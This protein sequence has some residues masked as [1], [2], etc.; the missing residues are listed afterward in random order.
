M[1]KFIFPLALLYFISCTEKKKDNSNDTT[2]LNALAEQYVRLGLSIGQYDKDFVDAYYGPDSLKP[3]LAAAAVF[4]KDS[5]LKAVNVLSAELKIFDSNANDTI[6]KRSAWL[7]S[8]L[9]AFERRIKLFGGDSASFDDECRELYGVTAPVYDSARFKNIIRKLDSLLPGKGT[10]NERMQQL[11]GR[12]IIPKEKLDTVLKA[13]IAECRK[14]TLQHY[15]L[16]ANENFSL[17][18][19]NNK[20]WSGYNWYKGNYHSVIQINTDL[21]IFIDRAIDV[22]SHESYP[23]HHVY[24]MLLEKNL[25]RDK[26]WVEA[27]LY[28]LYS[29][30]SLIAE[31][32]A[33]YGIALA[34]PG[35]EKARFAKEVLLPLAGLDTAG[36]SLYFKA[37]E[38]K[39]QLNYAR[40]EAGRG[41]LGG[42]MNEQQAMYWL[43]NFCLMNEETARKSISFIRANRGYIINYNYGKDLVKEYIELK[44]GIADRNKQWEAFGWL[45]SN[46]V[47]PSDLKK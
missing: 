23:G 45:L 18:F 1:Y 40:N 21:K 39:E 46:P 7:R 33:N 19:V 22:G 24:N 12:F 14:L 3:T 10:V 44:A 27:S 34:F 43:T 17:E 16:P 8:Q 36:I 35:E 20:P 28:P 41:L 30:Q 11:A 26:G 15:S 5:F 37:L 42:G 47:L 25:Y 38:L 6:V 29:P 13:A 32:S 4:P 2:Q 9:T 31:G